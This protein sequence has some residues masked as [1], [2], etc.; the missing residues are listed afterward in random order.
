VKSQTKDRRRR[1]AR[2]R[3]LAAKGRRIVRRELATEYDEALAD[4]RRELDK[5]KFDANRAYERAHDAA[6][7]DLLEHRRAA[8][9]RYEE[10]RAEILKAAARSEREAGVSK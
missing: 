2:E 6:R 4:A 8:W 9:E 10:R 3:S 1:K 7:K 5:A